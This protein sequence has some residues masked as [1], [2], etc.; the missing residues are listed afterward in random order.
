[1]LEAMKVP[2]TVFVNKDFVERS[3]VV[4]PFGCVTPGYLSVGEIKRM[5]ESGLVDI[6]SH[7]VTHTWYPTAPRVVDV[8]DRSHVAKYPWLLWNRNPGRKPFWLQE[9]Y[10]E[11]QGMPVF[12]N[13]RS[14]RARQYLFDEDRLAHFK[15]TV[16]ERHLNSD[17]ANA[18]LMAEYRDMGRLESDVEQEAATVQKS[19]RTLNLSRRS[20]AVT[21]QSCVGRVE[22]TTRFQKT[23]LMKFIPHPP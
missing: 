16:K 3:D 22:P 12:E 8:F 19:A 6:Q 1:M 9:N 21:R 2:Y 20:W 18:L 7:S 13:D 11:F 4:R 14:L 10:R 17:G 23:L 5:H 15:R